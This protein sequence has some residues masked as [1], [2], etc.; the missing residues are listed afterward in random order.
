M[1]GSGRA[2]LAFLRLGTCLVD[3][4]QL[5]T[6]RPKGDYW[7]VPIQGMLVR[8]GSSLFLFDCGMPER[9]IERAW[10]LFDD[11][12]AERDEIIPV[13]RPE[14]R[15]ASRLA[16]AGLTPRDLDGVI[17]SHWHFDHAGGMA[18]LKGSL[19]LAQAAELAAAAVPGAYTPDVHVPG[20]RTRSLEG[21]TELA[22]GVT[23]L[24]TPGHTPGHQSLLVETAEGP[25]LLTSD[26]VYTKV[27]WDTDTPGAMV[28]PASGVRSVA[29]LRQVASDTGATVVFSHDPV[30]ARQF[31]PFPHWYG[32]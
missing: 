2:S 17:T 21:D 12:E 20:L 15:I 11:V 24:S 26:A 6:G 32:A 30:Q 16:E 3:V 13:M 5:V 10:A 14:D 19:I 27:N 22:P 9:C 4:S 23:V 31:L 18:Q 25:F 8:S 7:N 1:A 29:R 28:D